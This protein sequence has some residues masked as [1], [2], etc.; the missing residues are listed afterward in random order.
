MATRLFADGELERLREF[1]EI[2]RDELFR[3][4]TLAPADLAFIAPQGRGAGV[5][6][7]LAVAVCTLPWLGFVPDNVAGALAVARLADQL[8]VDAALIRSY[9]K[10]AQTRTEHLRLAAHYLGWRQAGPSEPKELDEFLPARA[11]EHGPAP[12]STG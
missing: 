6:L 8:G 1:P 4:F 12:R 11:M 5:R 10:R 7:G 9:G 3:F 2:S